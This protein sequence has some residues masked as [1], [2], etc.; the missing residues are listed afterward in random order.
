VND[1][2][3]T[4]LGEDGVAVVTVDVPGQRVNTLRRDLAE[5]FEGAVASVAQV[6]GARALVL[7]SGKARGFIAGADLHALEAV[8]VSA[9]ASEL[10]SLMQRV[11]HRLAALPIP[12]VAAI[13]G[14]CL[15]GGLELA[16]ACDARVASDAD[17]TR[18]G[19]PEV[20]LGLLPAGGG[21]ERLPALVGLPAAMDLLL[22]GRR[23]GAARA[24]GIGLVDEVV[25]AG[26]L[27]Q[28]ACAL[29]LALADGGA[30]WR[31]RERPRPVERWSS[32]AGLAHRLL[33]ANP[34]GRAL[35][36]WRLS[37]EVTLRGAGNYPAPVRI[38]EVVRTGLARGATAGGAA[39]AR[40]FGELAV[41]PESRALVS[42]F[43]ASTALAKENGTDDPERVGAEVAT[44]AVVGTGLMG[45]GIA[46]VSALRAGARV[47]LRD[48]DAEAARR[49]REQVASALERRVRRGRMDAAARDEVRDAVTLG[50]EPADLAHVDLV[51]EAV[52]E[53]IEVKRR[54]LADFEAH[55]PDRAVF[56]S[57]TSAIPIREIAAGCRYPGRVAGMHYFSPVERMPLLEVVR[58]QATD[59]DT[60][61]TCVRFGQRQGKTVVVVGDGPGFYTTRILAPYMNE[62]AWLLSEGARPDA[63]DQALRAFGFPLGPLALLDS[64]GIDVAARV[65]ESL[66]EAFGERMRPPPVMR[67]LVV[68]GCLG[69]KDGRGVYRY[70]DRGPAGVDRELARRLG[71]RPRGPAPADAALRCVLPMVNEAARCLEEGVL[72]SPR[73]GDV[74]AVFGLGFP[75]FLGGPFR[76]ADAFGIAQIRARLEALEQ[77]HGPRFAPSDGLRE[78]AA[79]GGRFHA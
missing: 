14:E 20:Q 66:T 30:S 61:A 58:A 60:V 59:P 64:V 9:E 68:E 16:L 5:S 72:R 39:A 29:A 2:V 31:R 26:V 33:A 25:P 8:R 27:L 12:T 52:F 15:G 22:A 77:A 32:R 62:A 38:L 47:V 7:A 10:A 21:T 49:G 56:A 42:L 11:T 37:R 65:A 79:R 57:N 54:V 4:R 74:A 41:S 36:F 34:L 76:F 23:L 24:L 55:A 45:V 28:R 46:L 48:R 69:V 51:V 44:V 67:G 78:M 53:D 19:L 50:Q 6:P 3:T 35:A 75:P 40:A 17:S 18:L 13:H 71:V 63:V 1:A 73:D 70:R 43:F